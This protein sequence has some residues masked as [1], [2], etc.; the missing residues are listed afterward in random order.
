MG[1]IQKLFL[2]ESTDI[3]FSVSRLTGRLKRARY[4]EKTSGKEANPR[5][6]RRE[7]V[8]GRDSNISLGSLGLILFPVKVLLTSVFL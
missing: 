1:T 8:R 3:A 5:P 2:L 6:S 4:R 7:G